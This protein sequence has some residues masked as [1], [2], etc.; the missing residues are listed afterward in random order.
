MTRVAGGEGARDLSSAWHDEH[1]LR[2]TVNRARCVRCPV[3]DE[4]LRPAGAS[5]FWTLSR[6]AAALDGAAAGAHGYSDAHAGVRSRWAGADRAVRAVATDSRTVETGD[7][8]VALSGERFDGHDFLASAVA[9]GA[10][11]VV[12]SRSERAAGLGVPVFAVE[13]TTTA[14][15]T[16]ARFRRRAWG[17]PVVAIAGSNGKT[18][19]KELLRA[20][21]GSLLEVHATSGN[22]NN[23]VGV[24]LTLLATPDAADLAIVELDTNAPGEVALLRSIAEPDIAVVTSIG[25]EHLEGFGDLA[26]VLAEEA[27]VFEGVGLAVVP[28]EEKELVDAARARHAQVVTAGLGAGDVC[29]ATWRVGSMDCGELEIGGVQVRVPFRGVHNLRNA[30]LALAVAQACGIDLATAGAGLAE[31]TP[32]PMR[33][34]WETLGDLTL[35]NDAYNANPPSVRAAIAMLEA[36]GPGRQRVLILG[37]MRELGGASDRLH[38]DIARLALQSSFDVVAG[39]GAFGD[40]LGKIAAGDPRVIVARDVDDLWP[41]LQPRLAPNAI[42]L[43]KASRGVRL[44]RLVPPLTDWANS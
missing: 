33:S 41:A 10:A 35:I 38:T 7:L 11:A 3:S 9:R 22:Y 20:A 18:S 30:M 1:P 6:V 32:P 4:L 40:V 37:T 27:S 25:E 44:E 31:A 21:L 16:L 36:V 28:V 17:K 34:S 5:G 42:V 43:L 29:A 2:R 15:A 19:T 13:N 24:P 8:F 23:Q 39:V 12:V 26:G 14:L